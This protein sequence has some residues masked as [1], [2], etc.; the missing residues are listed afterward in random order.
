M[1]QISSSCA[2][3]IEN[4]QVLA[5]LRVS[6]CPPANQF[7]QSAIVETGCDEYQH[8]LAHQSKL[9]AVYHT[10]AICLVTA[11]AIRLAA[12]SAPTTKR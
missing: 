11:R 3:V 5:A 1:A 10:R 9:R 12:A 8:V 2:M 7:H 6:L 4:N